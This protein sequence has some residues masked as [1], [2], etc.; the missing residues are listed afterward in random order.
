MRYRVPLQSII[1]LV[2]FHDIIEIIDHKTI[3][4]EAG[5]QRQKKGIRDC[6]SSMNNTYAMKP[7]LV[8]FEPI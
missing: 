8:T 7:C 3:G 5:I 1:H 6:V 4:F 2:P